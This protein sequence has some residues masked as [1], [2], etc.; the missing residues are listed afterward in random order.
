MSGLYIRKFMDK[1]Q[2]LEL[3][4]SRDFVCPIND[5]KNLQKDITTLLL[6]MEAMR[7]HAPQTQE[8]VISVELKGEDF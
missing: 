4:G 5:A 8:E 1:L 7:S 3:K 2:Q 6:D